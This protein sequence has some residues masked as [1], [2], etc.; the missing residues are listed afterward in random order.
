MPWCFMLCL[1]YRYYY[2]LSQLL[3]S[4]L[5]QLGFSDTSVVLQKSTSSRPRPPAGCFYGVLPSP[6]GGKRQMM[7]NTNGANPGKCL[8]K[9]EWSM[10][11]RDNRCLCK[12]TTGSCLGGQA[13]LKHE[14]A[15]P[16]PT[17]V[18]DSTAYFVFTG[19]NKQGPW[20]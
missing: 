18:H 20:A 15:R 19:G 9:K 10:G 8:T 12:R 1:M 14:C 11:H 2:G 4:H 16:L 6:T 13:G 7:F 5:A 17:L 3:F